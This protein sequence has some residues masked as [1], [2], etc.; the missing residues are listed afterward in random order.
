[1]A[2][3][4][5]LVYALVAAGG[6]AGGAYAAVCVRI[7]WLKADTDRAHV[8]LDCHHRRLSRLETEN[9]HHA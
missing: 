5:H 9:H 2:D 7:D 3:W 4:L 8:R 6:A 1:M